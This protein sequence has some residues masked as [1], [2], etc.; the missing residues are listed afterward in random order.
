MKEI[1]CNLLLVVVESLFFSLSPVLVKNDP[2]CCRGLLS[3]FLFFTAVAFFFLLFFLF[4]SSESS[5]SKSQSEVS[6]CFIIVLVVLLGREEGEGG[7][8]S[9]TSSSSTS[10]LLLLLV[11][12]C[13]GSWVSFRLV[14]VM[15]LLVYH[16][17]RSLFTGTLHM[18]HGAANNF[19]EFGAL[20]KI[21]DFSYFQK[22]CR[23]LQSE[24]V[25]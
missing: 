20:A 8:T 6:S 1:R 16:L 3:S 4:S 12:G 24:F 15:E 9:F 21:F 17:Y 22:F 18:L 10:F 2:I 7:T 19:F 23:K 5:S 13:T 14:I 11:A 25:T